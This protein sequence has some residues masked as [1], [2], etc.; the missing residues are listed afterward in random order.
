MSK[1]Q[2]VA[3][4][5]PPQPTA[6]PA[7]EPTAKKSGSQLESLKQQSFEKPTKSSLI[8]NPGSVIPA[9]NA[10]KTKKQSKS[11]PHKPAVPPFLSQSLRRFAGQ[12]SANEPP[13]GSSDFLD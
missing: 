8:T 3:I 11:N 7:V 13:T 2:I 4:K 5:R 10:P 6:Q 1:L 9:T 12:L